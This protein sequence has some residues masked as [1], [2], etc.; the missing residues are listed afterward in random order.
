MLRYDLEKARS[1]WLETIESGQPR[2]EAEA[3]DFLK[4]TNSEGDK[5]DFHAL[6]HTT[7]TWLIDEGAD[8]KTLQSIMRHST[9]KLTIDLYGHLYPGSEAA[10]AS[11][12]RLLFAPENRQRATGTETALKRPL[13]RPAC[14][15]LQTVAI[16]CEA[17][18]IS[19]ELIEIDSTNEKSGETNVFAALSAMRALGLEPRTQGL[20]VHLDSKQFI[21]PWEALKRVLQRLKLPGNNGAAE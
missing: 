5:I 19:D 20:K 2:I 15:T 1:A 13:Q 16:G 7:A 12:L 6:R 21:V 9:I 8:L 18:P 10:A 4:A 3:G 14:E 17:E 11:K